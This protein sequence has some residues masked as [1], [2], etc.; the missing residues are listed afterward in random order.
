MVYSYEGKMRNMI[1]WVLIFVLLPLMALSDPPNSGKSYGPKPFVIN[2]AKSEYGG[3]NQNWSVSADEAGIVYFGNN[4]GMLSFDGSNWQLYNLPDESVV[5]SLK[6]GPKNRVYVGAYEE[7]GYFETDDE[8]RKTYISLSDSIDQSL[9]HNDEIWRIILNEGKVY[10]Q[11]FTSIFVWNGRKVDRI[12][13]GSPVVLLHKARN[14]LFIHKIDEGLFELKER[15][16]VFVEGSG[17]LKD[18]EIKMV[19]PFGERKFLVGAAN[20]GLFIYDGEHFTP[21]DIPLAKA[22]RNAEINCGLA[23]QD[24]YAIGTI[25]KGIYILDSDGNL[26]SH[27]ST[28]NEL[29]NN[30]VLTL[31]KDKS[32][33]IWAGLD[34][35]IDYIALEPPLDF[36][37]DKSGVLGSVYAAALYQDALWVGTNRGLYKYRVTSKNTFSDPQMIEGSQGQVWSLD[38]MD[39]QLICGH[40]NGTFTVKTDGSLTQVSRINGGFEIE[41]IKIGKKEVLLQSTYSNLVI[42]KK[43]DGHWKFSNTV[44][45]FIEPVP[46]FEVDHKGNIWASHLNEGL[47]R[48]RL[49]S[50]LDSV[51]DVRFFSERDG[52]KH[53]REVQVSKV[54]GRIVFATGHL[55]YTYDDLNDTIIP[56]TPLNK[57]AGEF[58]KTQKITHDNG[59][60]YWFVNK[61]RIGLFGMKSNALN[62]LFNY[63]LYQQGLYMSSEYPEIIMLSDT[64]HLICLDNGFAVYKE[65]AIDMLD[66][67]HVLMRKVKVENNRGKVK[68]LPLEKRAKKMS[69]HNRCRN[70]TFTYST[71]Q[72][73][74]H[75]VYRFKLKGLEKSAFSNWTGKSKVS[76]N[77]LPAGDYV[78]IVQSKNV[79]G[80]V[81]NTLTYPFTILPPWY[82]SDTAIIIYIIL[83]IGLTVYLRHLFLLRLRK[84]TK[85]LE[86][87]EK[88]KR[89]RERMEARQELMKVKNEKLQAE[90]NHKNVELANHTM[91][92]INKNDLLIGIKNE[93]KNLKKKLGT[94]FPNYYY[95]ELVKVIDKNISSEDEWKKFEAH[96]DE[97][98]ENFFK[99]LMNEYPDL[100]QSDL[101]LCA[102]L[103]M[104]LSTKEIAP[105]LNISIRGVEARRYRLR[106]R[107]N[108]DH[109][110]NLVEFL[111][112]F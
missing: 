87:D 67:G 33:N 3:D 51:T 82:A 48:I 110:A 40:N 47:F 24:T 83:F 31:A 63:N 55:I 57:Q 26:R 65:Q 71:T 112:Q 45:G 23:L 66:A 108:L 29:Q 70:I 80:K 95:R 69:L 17:F 94:Q 76:F 75:P 10:F 50:A 78:F 34:R 74:V 111:L 96:F 5:R 12:D 4:A 22:I 56:H 81:S 36:Y 11:S 107:L 77:R 39:N 88:E 2:Y 59:R 21:W 42:Y 61:N 86:Q 30:T 53:D 99:R 98:H 38:V 9:F 35:G 90:L 16:L 1:R 6:A 89:E 20:K 62:R 100:T 106:K 58:K 72:K 105:L 92:V 91:N 18:D 7:F 41:K 46:T 79:F 37:I 19:I 52:L 43:E 28:K 109:D 27:L 64:M 49:N 84:H 8:G 15:K 13:P 104:N 97:I 73:Y 85:K 93:I 54:N 68:Y 101:K 32:G 44:E 103:R 60:Y 102:Y 14:R 25:V